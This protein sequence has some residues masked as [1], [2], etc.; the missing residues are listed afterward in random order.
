VKLIYSGPHDA[1][2]VELPNGS[3]VQTVN[4]EPVEFP[5]EVA[6]SLLMQAT[7][8]KASPET[9]TKKAQKAEE[10]DK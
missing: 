4:G 5:E 10:D 6:K 8:S 3:Y 7:W 2:E 1:V 9:T